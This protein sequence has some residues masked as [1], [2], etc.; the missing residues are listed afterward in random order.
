MRRCE[1]LLLALLV[2][3]LATCQ[4]R[5]NISAAH[6]P[7]ASGK[8]KAAAQT[9]APSSSQSDD[10]VLVGAGDIA[11]C[12]DLVGA[13]ATAKLID[14]IPGTVFAVGDLAYPD[15]SDEQFAKCYGPTWGRFKERTRP[16]PGNHEYQG[17]G[18]ASGYVRYFGAAA[19]DPKKAYYSYDLGAWHIVA[20]NSECDHVEGCDAAS[21]QLNGYAKISVAILLPARSLTSISHFLAPGRHMATIPLSSRCGKLFTMRAQRL[22]SADTITTMKDLRRRTLKAALIPRTVSAN[23]SLEPVAK[24]PI[25]FWQPR[26]QTVRCAKP[27]PTAC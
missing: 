15:G 22:S 10:P 6:G 1:R 12:D 13:Q 8:R 20:L 24:I 5:T 4:A 11:S 19:G 18:G 25:A 23:S 9:K 3:S 14:K 16:A 27:T 26:N 21:P 7:P 2:I 17:D